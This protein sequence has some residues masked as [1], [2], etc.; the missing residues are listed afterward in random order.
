MPGPLVGDRHDQRACGAL[1]LRARTRPGRRPRSEAR[2]ARSRR[3]R[4]RCASGPGR[5]SRAARRSGARAGARPR[6]RARSAWRRWKTAVLDAC[7]ASRDDH[8]RVVAS[9]DNGRGTAR[10]RSARDARCT[11]RG[12]SQRSS[13]SRDAVGVQDQQ[14]ASRPRDRRTPAPCA[15]RGRR[16]RC[17]ET[18][19]SAS[20]RRSR[21]YQRCCRRRRSRTRPPSRSQPHDGDG[22]AARAAAARRARPGGCARAAGPSRSRRPCAPRPRAAVAARRPVAEAVGHQ[23]SSRTSRPTI[24]VQASPLPSS[25]GFGTQTPPATIREGACS[26]GGEACA[27]SPI[28]AQ[29]TVPRPGCA[30]D[31]ERRR[32]A[33]HRAEAR[34]R[35]CPRSSSRRAAL[36]ARFGDARP[37]SS[38]RSRSPARLRRSSRKSSAPPP[39]CLTRFVASSVATSAARPVD[40]SLEAA[41]PRRSATAARR[42]SADLARVV[43]RVTALRDPDQDAPFP[44]RDRDPRAFAGLRLDVELVRQPLRAAQ[45]EA[46]PAAGGVAV[47]QRQL[48]V[49]DARALVLERQAQTLARC[50]RSSDLEQHVAAAA[51][52]ERVARELAGRGDDLG[53]VD[54]AEA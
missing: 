30:I 31:V 34:A 40:V 28:V 32:C 7:Q 46:Q 52:V 50:R 53:L 26:T 41:A 5:R 25:P 16:C 3:R 38:A 49:R 22:R 44:A 24:A 51:V 14:R 6:R 2:C 35:R 39:A 42:A 8:G 1:R 15:R 36:A 19:R 11:A 21:S 20:C 27:A 54:Q 23:R 12:S 47:L 45:A 48:D 17:S 18:M 9:R 33:A 43:G 4:W 29:T 37:L 10:P 13:A